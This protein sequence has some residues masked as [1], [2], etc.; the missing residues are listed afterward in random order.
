VWC[1]QP[2]DVLG[3]FLRGGRWITGRDDPGDEP[4]PKVG[5]RFTGYRRLGDPRM[6]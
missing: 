6:L 3:E 4:L 1:E 5:I 2:R